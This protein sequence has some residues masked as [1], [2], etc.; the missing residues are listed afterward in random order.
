M[1]IGYKDVIAK[2]QHGEVGYAVPDQE[3]QLD[4]NCVTEN[5]ITDVR[6]TL[7]GQPCTVID[8]PSAQA[9]IEGHPRLQTTA[10]SNKWG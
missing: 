3:P 4:F 10:E 6:D 9:G 7:R 1:T 5:D 8:R 2:Y